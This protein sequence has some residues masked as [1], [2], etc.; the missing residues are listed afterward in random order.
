VRC[1]IQTRSP[2]QAN[3]SSIARGKARYIGAEISVPE[4]TPADLF[5]GR[6]QLRPVRTLE[7]VLLF[8]VGGC[9]RLKRGS[10]WA[11]SGTSADKL[12][13]RNARTGVEEHSRSSVDQF[14]VNETLLD[15]GATEPTFEPIF[16]EKECHAPVV[17]QLHHVFRCVDCGVLQR[18][19]HRYRIDSH[20]NAVG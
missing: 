2:G 5:L 20:E 1:G 16:G 3:R 19:I 15:V 14:D 7:G 17:R 8:T 11:G 18:P 10:P 13:S 6:G 4:V 9:A 12:N